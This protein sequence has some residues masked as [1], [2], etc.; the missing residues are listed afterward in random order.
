[1]TATPVAQPVVTQIDTTTGTV[2][3]TPVQLPTT[4]LPLIDT[5]TQ[6]NANQI[7]PFNGGV[8]VPLQ[9]SDYQYLNPFLIDFVS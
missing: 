3:P 5:V 9:A 6:T 7:D 8:Q 2:A 1:V 4:T